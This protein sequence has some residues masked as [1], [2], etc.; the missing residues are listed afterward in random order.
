MTTISRWLRLTILVTLLVG[1]VS[2]FVE[3]EASPPGF[4]LDEAII[5]AHAI[6]LRETGSDAYGQHLPLFSA[7]ADGL[8]TPVQLYGSAAWTVIFG[9]SIASLRAW[10]AFVSTITIGAIALLVWKWGFEAS[11]ATWAAMLAAISPWAFQFS[12]IAWDPPLAPCFLVL[13]MLALFWSAGALSALLAG[14]SFALAMYSYPPLRVQVLLLAPALVLLLRAEKSFTWRRVAIVAFAATV[15][16][17]PIVLRNSAGELLRRSRALSIFSDAY[18]EPLGG[19]SMPRVIGIFLSNFFSHFSWSYLLVSGDANVRHS[20]QLFGEWSWIDGVLMVLAFVLLLKRKLFERAPEASLRKRVLCF[21][22]YGYATGVIPAALTNDGLPH[23]LRSI[24]AWP[25]LVIGLALVADRL[26]ELSQHFPGLLGTA[27]LVYFCFFLSQYFSNYPTFS[28]HAFHA[29]VEK[30]ALLSE[31][32]DDW[33][34]FDRYVGNYIDI[35]KYYY[36]MHYGHERCGQVAKHKP[37]Q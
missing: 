9:D 12:R 14:A 33:R 18:L 16:L 22:I 5:A 20:T 10:S 37:R 27:S 36:Y 4:Y 8:A 24:A 31:S 30:A 26:G 23:A 28:R 32:R 2:R 13:G 35:G 34:L 21:A 6:C 7:V 19:F 29:G 1:L 11:A 3:L 17:T 15:V 25:F